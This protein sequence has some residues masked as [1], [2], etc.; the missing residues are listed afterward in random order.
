M[1]KNH[2]S[3]PDGIE[4]LVNHLSRFYRSDLHANPDYLT[5]Q[6]ECYLINNPA[7]TKA[8]IFQYFSQHRG[9]P[10]THASADKDSEDI[11]HGNH[12]KY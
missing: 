1:A 3:Q 4:S 2:E 12:H 9:S 8:E 7:A 6:I 11:K 5:Q 10:C